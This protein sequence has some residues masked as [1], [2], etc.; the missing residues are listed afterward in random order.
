[1]PTEFAKINSD[2]LRGLPRDRTVFFF[3][4]GPLENHGPHLPL[5]LDLAESTRIA[6]LTAEKM[7][8][9]M[10]GWTGVLMPSAPLGIDSNSREAAI[11][12]RP[13]I[14]RDWLVDSCRSLTRIG[15]QNYV[16]FSG[17]LGPKQLTAIEEA[18]RIVS[19]SGFWGLIFRAFSFGFK[20][21]VVLVS[22]S[23]AL[24]N[25]KEVKRSPLEPRPLEHG[26]ERDTSVALAIAKQLVSPTYSALPSS[27]TQPSR[28][29]SRLFAS[30]SA[31]AIYWG[32]PSSA[33]AAN[34]EKILTE[35]VEDLFPK[36]RAVWEGA[37]PQA[38]FRSWYS[39]FPPN[40]SFY[41][42]WLLAMMLVAL[43]C[44]WLWVAVNSGVGE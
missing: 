10:Q 6:M 40:R 35:T 36:L 4:V 22:A 33:T 41:R 31:R 8:R 38:I 21:R 44:A 43:I 3:P 25:F 9:E 15:F 20:K 23:S 26:G 17:N 13:Y 16:C 28:G 18:G 24:V 29:V 7:E 27:K 37:N 11:T 34:G 19:G 39:V 14:L 30:D 42:A 12:V 1:M 2:Q 5:G 32:N